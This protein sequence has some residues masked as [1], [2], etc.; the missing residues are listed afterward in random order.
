MGDQIRVTLIAGGVGGAKMAEGF[1][2]H[3]E[4]ALTVIGNVADDEEFHGLWVSPDIDTLT[5]TL[6]GLVDREQGWGVA[7]EGLRTLSVLKTLGSET[8]MMLGDKDFGLHI[9]RTERRRRGDRPSDIAR[10]VATCF[11]VGPRIVLPTDD[12]VQTRV[13]TDA[14]WLSFQ[15]YFVRERCAPEVRELAYDGLAAARPTPEAIAALADANLIVIAPSNPLVSIAPILSIAGIKDAVAGAAAP[16]YAVSPLIAGKVVKGPADRM[17]ASLGMR[18][19]AAGVAEVYAGLA[20]LL[21]IDDADE[22]LKVE[23]A[24]LGVRPVCRN[25]LM[26]DLAAKAALAGELLALFRKGREEQAA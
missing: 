22:G 1:A 8:W 12:R 14:G 11:G 17:M 2:A 5:Y 18:A 16:L 20:D 26:T 25:I 23:I 24:A 7:D 4:V 19:D 13:R 6:S 21:L 9:Y 15:E 3:D 10:D